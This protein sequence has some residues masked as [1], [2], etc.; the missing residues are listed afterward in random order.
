M[1]ELGGYRD[2]L[3]TALPRYLRCGGLHCDPTVPGGMW[4]APVC[5]T[6]AALKDTMSSPLKSMASTI[7]SAASLMETSSSS[8][9]V[10]NGDELRP[11]SP[12]FLPLLE[13]KG[14]LL[15]T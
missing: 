3:G 10:G 11:F 5:C 13:R 7:A 12:P 15:L 2:A 9:T 8:P 4:G 6:S 1:G 14:K